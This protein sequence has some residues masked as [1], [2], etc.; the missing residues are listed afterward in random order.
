M[1][2]RLMIGA[3]VAL[4]TAPAMAQF[5]ANALRVNQR[6]PANTNFVARDIQPPPPGI[7]GIFIYN[8]SN[9]LPE[10]AQVGSGLAYSSGVLTAS[11]PNTGTP[12]TYSSVTTDAQGRVTAGT[13]RSFAYVTRSLN[14]CFQVSSTRDALVS[15]AVDIQTTLSLTSGQAGTVYLETFTNSGCTTGTQEV[16]RFVNGN[17]GVLTV[18][19]SLTQNVT[20]TL[21]GIVS[22]GR[23][24]KL[25]T[26]NNTG[27]PVFTARPGQ[28]T[29]L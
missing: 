12:G 20:G 3:L 10:L 27:A 25:R 24:L 6:D 9:N 16:T 19:L 17:T 14:A 21:T 7:D 11:F 22:A 2:S 29:L 8:Q 28:E 13:A 5:T 4:L 15:Y 1:K 18:G 26:E 23:W